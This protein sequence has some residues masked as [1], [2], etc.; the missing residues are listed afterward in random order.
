MISYKVYK[1]VNDDLPDLVYY[2]STIGTLKARFVKHKFQSKK[3]LCKSYKLFE[4]GNPKIIELDI[5]NNELEMYIKERE[6]IEN[7]ECV[8]FS[9]P[10]LK[11]RDYSKGKIYKIVNEDL[12]DLVYYGSTIQTIKK[13]FNEHKSKN[14]V[15]CS[16]KLFKTDKVKIELVENYPCNTKRELEIREKYYILKFEC[17]NSS[18]PSNTKTK[19]E[20]KIKM[21][22][23][24]ENNKESIKIQQKKYREDNKEAIKIKKK[25]Y[26]EDN[27]EAINK[28]KS[29][30]VIC[31]CGSIFRKDGKAEH[32]RTIKHKKYLD[33]L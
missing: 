7:N 21:K 33:T 2:G 32:E 24:R 30:K 1:I 27:K 11:I 16:K 12:P 31:D 19:E 6:Y 18:V 14:N 3:Q 20:L 29:F 17:I 15:C 10:S 13:R 25:K 23:Y 4:I 9:L 28:R 5:F 22:K 26:Q 8:N